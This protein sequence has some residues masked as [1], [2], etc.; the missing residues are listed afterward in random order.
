MCRPRIALALA[1]NRRAAGSLPSIAKYRGKRDREIIQD[2]ATI[3]LSVSNTR[4]REKSNHHGP[5]CD[6]VQGEACGAKEV[7]CE[8]LVAV[9]KI[10]AIE[11]LPP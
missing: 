4:S 9:R 5:R 11:Y 1:L 10:L 3:P 6:Q 2:I 8:C 7:S